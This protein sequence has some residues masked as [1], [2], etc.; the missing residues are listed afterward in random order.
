M[1]DLTAKELERE[2]DRL[3]QLPREEF[4]SAR[5]ALSRRTSGVGASRVKALRKPSAS[6]WLVNQLYGN[7]PER[8]HRIEKAA[9]AL[10]RA[11]KAAAAGRSGDVQAA[12]RAHREAIEAAFHRAVEM[13]GDG[14]DAASPAF[15]REILHT[16]QA[17][18]GAE[19]P[20]R[21]TKALEPSGFDVFEGAGFPTGPRSARSEPGR[22]P[23]EPAQAKHRGG[24]DRK[25]DE[26]KRAHEVRM[27]VAA[28]QKAF[29]LSRTSE[30]RARAL[31]R[32]ASKA[33]DSAR[34]TEQK[35]RAAAER[36][37]KSLAE[38]ERTVREA[39]EALRKES[40]TMKT[41][42]DALEKARERLSAS[43]PS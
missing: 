40:E 9:D 38:Q 11:M 18:P 3:Y 35:A 34:K 20:G 17:F 39:E 30:A 15:R 1:A 12:N 2:I 23:I 28:A 26:R 31:W 25:A 8:I 42:K 6:A 27:A 33:L 19:R 29:S 10:R 36:A 41:S 14:G 5:T 21:L 24:L 4:V 7:E 32:R 16:L 22:R 13:F 37:Q 43:R